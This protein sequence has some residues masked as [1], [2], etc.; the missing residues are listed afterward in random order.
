MSAECLKGLCALCKVS[1]PGNCTNKLRVSKL[2]DHLCYSEDAK[3][4]I[5]ALFK[6]EKEGEKEGEGDLEEMPEDE[7]PELDSR[8]E[9]ELLNKI[10]E[11]SEMKSQKNDGEAKKA[12]QSDA[13]PAKRAKRTSE[14][15]VDEDHP[16]VPESLPAPFAQLE[17]R[18]DMSDVAVPPGCAIRMYQGLASP[19]IH[20]SLPPGQKWKGKASHSRSFDPNASS[21]SSAAAAPAAGSRQAGRAALTE[22]AARAAVLAWLCEWATAQ[23]VQ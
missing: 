9:A 17:A 2:L 19:Y 12:N 23:G 15:P 18:S 6:K 20:G 13:P 4:A 14:P 16:K 22:A 5:L 8:C 10:L 1:L 11:S 21:S 3:N 7:A